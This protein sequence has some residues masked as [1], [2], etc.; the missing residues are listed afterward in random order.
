M[1]P[2]KSEQIRTEMLNFIADQSKKLLGFFDPTASVEV[3][4][5]DLENIF[6]VDVED[7]ADSAIL[8]GKHGRMLLSMQILIANTLRKHFPDQE[9]IVRLDIDGYQRL[10]K[11]KL[12]ER[13]ESLAQK[14][15]EQQEDVE[16]E[17][18]NPLERRW[19]HQFINENFS[20]KLRTE[21]EGFGRDRKL[22]IKNKV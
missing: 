6:E 18:V 21:S 7:C 3:N 20:D 13:V 19:I 11:E 1:E 22:F 5:N 2:V 9:S 8:I 12:L 4:F 17:N 10:R 14:S 15:I 16:V